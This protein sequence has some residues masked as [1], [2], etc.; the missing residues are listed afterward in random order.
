MNLITVG[1][2]I[3]LGVMLGAAVPADG[4]PQRP[5][6]IWITIDDVG[7]DFGCYGN[8]LVRTP[9]LDALAARGQRFDRSFVSTPVCSAVRSSLITGCY[10]TTIGSHQH[11]SSNPLAEGYAPITE[12][13]GAGGY[14]C[15][16][17]PIER[18]KHRDF[19][20]RVVGGGERPER[21]I[22][23][24]T[25]RLKL[26]FNFNRG[27]DGGVFEA[28]DESKAGEPFFAMI[29]FNPQKGPAKW[30]RE[31]AAALGATVDPGEVVIHPYW[32][33]TPEMRD[34]VA[35]YNE[36]VSV[37]DA[38]IGEVL[39]WLVREGMTENTVVMVW[40][41]HGQAAFRHKQ[42]CYDSGL[43]VP[44]IVAGPGVDPAVRSELVSSIDL[45]AATLRLAGIERPAWMEGRDFL[46]PD[47]EPRR[48]V[49]A[50]RDRC[51]ET[52]DRV[53]AVRTARYKLIRNFHPERGYIDRN[54]YT[55]AAFLEV[56]QLLAMRDAGEL[57]EVQERWCGPSKPAWEFYDLEADPLE[58]DNRYDDPTFTR[59]IME[60]EALLNAWIAETD[61]NNPY[62]ERMET[63][64]PAKAH[65]Q[66]TE[67]RARAGR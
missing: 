10:A 1:F 30:A 34:R 18:V 43:R 51:D 49:F 39:G 56:R 40:G 29:D 16:Q 9:H 55:R 6:I 53:R 28:W 22:L 54:D 24:I 57:S 42:W 64:V 15:T 67:Q 3:A 46:E 62:P 48:H 26:D 8:G 14:R 32:P 4:Q 20:G 47:A 61:A 31:S 37:L 25:G 21:A 44:L 23:T 52:E 13:L 36:A 63:I 66:V 45:A 11:R 50:S 65:R 12:L 7:P 60:L 38:E 35:L 19:V 33:D 2:S 27:A 5:N 58:L 41:D 17:L 59:E